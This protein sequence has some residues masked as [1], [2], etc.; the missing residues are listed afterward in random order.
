MVLGCNNASTEK[1]KMPESELPAFQQQKEADLV[2]GF[3]TW[4]S[5]GILKP[6]VPGSHTIRYSSKEEF[7]KVLADLRIQK[8]LVV[9]VIDKRVDPDGVPLELRMDDV[10]AVMRR[11]GFKR[12]VF[13][14]ALGDVDPEGL[15]ILRD[16][17]KAAR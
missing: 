12:I 13:Q 4:K 2:I 5:I 3:N 10:E 14:L 8:R 15:P 16:S 11:A 7:A 17:A 9:V 6:A 1:G